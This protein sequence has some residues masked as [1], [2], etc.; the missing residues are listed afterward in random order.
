MVVAVAV[1]GVIL[2][3]QG[4][5]YVDDH[6]NDH[7]HLSSLLW[8]QTP[9]VERGLFLKSP[10]PHH[11]PHPHRPPPPRASNPGLHG[12]QNVEAGSMGIPSPSSG[13]RLVGSDTRAQAL[14]SRAVT[15]STGL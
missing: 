14:L 6:E 11:R 7:D 4:H 12:P 9:G 5:G 2:L 13:I 1:V 15:P 3:G 10:C 8:G